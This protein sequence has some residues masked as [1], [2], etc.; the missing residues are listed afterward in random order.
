MKTLFL[1]FIMHIF[2][3]QSFIMAQMIDNHE[4]IKTITY[5]QMTNKELYAKSSFNDKSRFYNDSK[6][7]TIQTANNKE[8]KLLSISGTIN[9]SKSAQKGDE[10]FVYAFSNSTETINFKKIKYNNVNIVKYKIDKLVSANDYIVFVWSNKF[11]TQLFCNANDIQNAIK[12]DTSD[13][14][15]D[16]EVNFTLSKG[17]SISGKVV[18]EHKSPL[19]N[20]EVYAW[21]D[22]GEIWKSAI[23]DEHGNYMI[24]GLDP[25]DDYYINIYTE[26]FDSLYYNSNYPV[27]NIAHATPVNI[28]KNSRY[29]IDIILKSSNKHLFGSINEKMFPEN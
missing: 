26:Q 28:E 21:S 29:G 2:L 23:T 25:T 22:K 6:L 14:N 10:I 8:F 19:A 15:P 16:N 12:V 27:Q 24:E 13:C 7:K 9:F 1:S 18:N 3:N 17:S 4:L 20:I 5:N 11:R